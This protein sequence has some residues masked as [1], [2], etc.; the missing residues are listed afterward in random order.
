MNDFAD[1][2]SAFLREYL[3]HERGASQYTCDAYAYTFQ[4]LICFAAR[5]LKKQPSKLKLEYFN[6]SLIIDFLNQLEKARKNTARTRN[7]RLSAIK[8]F[9][10]SLEYRVPSALD[11]AS[12]ILAIPIKKVEER[13]VDFLT[14]KEMQALLDSPDP[15]TKNWYT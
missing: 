4:L 2:L 1:Y 14:Q 13:L 15:K 5:K 3:P 6:V 7:A 10:R 11:Q 9:F 12:R 8:A